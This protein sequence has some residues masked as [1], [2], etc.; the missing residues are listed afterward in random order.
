MRFGSRPLWLRVLGWPLGLAALG[1]AVWFAAQQVDGAIL[2]AVPP[3]TLAAMTGL[4]LANLVLSGLL[5]WS[6]HRVLPA[7]KPVPAITMV[8]LVAGSALLNYLPA[9]RAGLFGRAAYLKKWHGIALRDSGWA[10]LIVMAV[11]AGVFAAVAG[12]WLI[13]RLSTP[14]G[15][16]AHGLGWFGCVLATLALL[17]GLRFALASFFAGKR[18]LATGSTWSPWLWL[19]GWIALRTT[20]L[21]SATGRLWLAFAALGSPIGFTEALVLSAASLLV[22]LIGLTPNGLGLSEWTVAALSSVLSPAE[23]GVAAAAALLDRAVEV[24]AVI[25]LGGGAIGWLV[26]AQRRANKMAAR[27]E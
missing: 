17:P 12:P 2:A 16:T 27:Q 14:D 23:S 24:V 7:E 18:D 26:R 4:V 19:A 3:A 11:T 22:R 8:G 13:L 5:F 21:L 20:D 1:A 6:V 25:V 9:I 10:L 15:H